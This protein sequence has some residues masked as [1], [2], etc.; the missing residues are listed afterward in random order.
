MIV[1]LS[2]IIELH[3]LPL[4][5]NEFNELIRL[6]RQAQLLKRV[7]CPGIDEWIRLIPK[8]LDPTIE[9]IQTRLPETFDTFSQN[10]PLLINGV[11]SL[12]ADLLKVIVPV[13]V[14]HRFSNQLDFFSSLALVL[15]AR[16]IKRLMNLPGACR[17]DGI[18]VS[19]LVGWIQNGADSAQTQT[20]RN[21]A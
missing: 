21:W 17:L 19:E 15:R 2:T 20:V 13:V 18:G 14:G 9:D 5:L 8:P 3:I 1:E 16:V 7:L 6:L 10:F 11:L 12:L 4:L